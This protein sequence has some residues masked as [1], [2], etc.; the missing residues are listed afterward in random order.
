MGVLGQKDALK[1]PPPFQSA[2]IFLMCGRYR[3]SRRK[4]LVEEYFDCVS[5]EPDWAPRYNI[6]RGY[7][8]QSG[9]DEG[10]NYPMP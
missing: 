2:I 6:A 7:H 9:F 3:L 4:Q 10:S 5:D 1:G 8:P